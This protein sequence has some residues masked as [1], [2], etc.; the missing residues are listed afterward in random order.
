MTNRKVNIYNL[1]HIKLNKAKIFN[2]LRTNLL[3]ILLCFNV[4]VVDAQVFSLSSPDNLGSVK[5]EVE[6]G[7]VFYTYAKNEQPIIQQSL[8]GV[9]LAGVDLKNVAFRDV[10]KERIRA[11]WKPLWGTQATYPNNYNSMILH[12][13]DINTN[14]SISYNFRLYDEGLAFIPVTI[15][16]AGFSGNEKQFR[17]G[18]KFTSWLFPY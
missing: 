14:V 1:I 7:K 17:Q 8:L 11:S 4:A 10:K 5:V 16:D 3:L 18:I 9:T 13:Q 12:L 6:A 15:Q 2:R